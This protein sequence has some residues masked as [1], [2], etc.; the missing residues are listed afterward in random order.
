M[1]QGIK[2]LDL[3]ALHPA[4]RTDCVRASKQQVFDSWACMRHDAPPGLQPPQCRHSRP[5]PADEGRHEE[6]SEK[7]QGRICLPD[8]YCS[9]TQAAARQQRNRRRQRVRQQQRR[10]RLTEQPHSPRGLATASVPRGH[11][12]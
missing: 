4:S 10:H 9:S 5:A 3:H 1:G 11:C 7:L 8:L 6:G 12:I 2:S